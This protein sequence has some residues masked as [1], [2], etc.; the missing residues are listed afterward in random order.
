M[1]RDHLG[2]GILIGYECTHCLNRSQESISAARQ[3][4]DEA[5]AG[6]RI[7]QRV[8][9]LASGS[10]EAAVEI[11]VRNGGPEPLFQLLTG[12]NFAGTFQQRGQQLKWLVLEMNL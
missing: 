3:R 7:S 10:V 8:T 6:S 12:D 2:A 4:L 9:Q 1:I 5:R 11:D